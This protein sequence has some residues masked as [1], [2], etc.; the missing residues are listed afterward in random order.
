[1]EQNDAYE[2]DNIKLTG[3][4]DRLVIQIGKIKKEVLIQKNKV[5]DG[6]NEV[7]LEKHKYVDL[8]KSKVA[9][10]ARK[11][12]QIEN[13][14]IDHKEI[15]IKLNDKIKEV[16]SL[17]TETKEKG[18]KIVQKAEKIVHMRK[19]QKELKV[20]LKDEKNHVKG[21]LNEAKRILKMLK[22]GLMTMADIKDGF[23]LSDCSSSEDSSSS[24][25]SGSE[26]E[27]VKNAKAQGIVTNSNIHGA[28]PYG[29][30]STKKGSKKVVEL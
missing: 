7:N 2:T 14:E 26:A 22:Q 19:E 24:N 1:M 10:L 9:A 12:K 25:N 17:N 13:A 28:G 21:K 16:F 3:E 23:G 18:I 29:S 6:E 4:V 30:K 15:E 11:D 5:E 20:R 8:E 27:L